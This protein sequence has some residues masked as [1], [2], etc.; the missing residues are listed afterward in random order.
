[1]D[2]DT[3]IPA[4]A[5]TA[6]GL[7]RRVAA[8]ETISEV[9]RRLGVIRT[10]RELLTS[11]VELVR[12]RLGYEAAALLL[13]DPTG[14]ELV[15][16][17]DSGLHGDSAG[18]R[19]PLSDGRGITAW[20]ATH[21]Q[22]LLADDVRC[23]PRY[24]HVGDHAPS[25]SELAV[26]IEV[27]GRV[28]GVLDVQSA[29]TNAFDAIDLSTLQTLAGQIAVALENARLHEQH[30]QT[31]RRRAAFQGILTAITA[32]LDLPVTLER[33]LDAAMSEFAADRAAIFF[34][35]PGSTRTQCVAARNLSHAYLTAVEACYAAAS[36]MPQPLQQERSIFIEDAQRGSLVPGMAEAA[37]QEG[38]HTQILL[39]LRDGARLLGVFVLYHDVIRPYSAE[40]LALVQT[41]AD[42]AAIATTHARLHQ[43]TERA[44]RRT[45]A[46]QSVTN[47]ITGSLDLPTTLERALDAAMGIF[48]ADRAAIMLYRPQ[49]KQMQPAASRNL[50]AGFLTAVHDFYERMPQPTSFKRLKRE[51]S[52]YV[53]DAQRTPPIPALAEATAR[54]GFHSM[55]IV[56]L[57]N[58]ANLHGVFALFHDQIRRYTSEEIALVQSLA[59]QA[60]VAVEHA[61][62]Y[63]DSERALQR[64]RA[65]QSVS[66]A[67]TGS[68]DLPTTLEHALGAAME[69]FGADRAAIFLDHP[70]TGHTYCAAS[71]NLSER[72]LNAV[73]SHYQQAGPPATARIDS[74]RSIYVQDAQ[75]NP[76]APPL[77]GAA[78]REGFRSML[79]LPLYDGSLRFG[80]FV[81]YHDDIRRY[82]D[83]EIALAQTFAH[84]ARIAIVHAR[85][86]E[87]E[88]RARQQAATILDATRAVASS[89]QLN[90]VLREA[91]GCI[92]AALHQ[93]Y[94]GVWLLDDTGSVL[95]PVA[96]VADPPDA[97]LER[98]F[99]SMPPLV[100]DEYPQLRA[101]LREGRACLEEDL[102]SV[103][104]LPQP[105]PAA[106]PFRSYLSVP[107]VTRDQ[108]LG[109]FSVA[110][111]EDSVTFDPADIEVAL[112]IARSAALAVE[113]A[114]LYEQAQRLA[115]S[116]ERNRLA[117]ELHDSVTQSLFSMTLICQAL[118]RIL[119]R[120]PERA[121]E[122]LDRLN[123]LGRGALA[124]MRALIFELRPAALEDEGLVTALRKH[125]DAF[126]SREAILVEFEVEGERRLPAAIEEGIFRVAQ[127]AL[128][129]V[130]KHAAA[131]RVLLRLK[132][133]EAQAE[134]TVADD[135]RGFDLE[136]PHGGRRTLGL[137][138]MEERA[139]IL[140]GRYTITSA[141]GR[142]TTVSLWVPLH[143]GHE[144]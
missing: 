89:L 96:A 62:L 77:A 33:T 38:F 83:E 79:F 95:R 109:V 80:V 134:L 25:G 102:A 85:L 7:S 51:H 61:R 138:S 50:S 34:D 9:G 39:P 12:A 57:R 117:R 65:F 86:F 4:D 97:A 28:L 6:A 110:V 137:T 139:S 44:L 63:Q 93:R 98:T 21:N 45:R 70:Q 107:L 91:A 124:E 122:R 26:P 115:V 103:C 52:I 74:E 66:T 41:F 48:G 94:C 105:G 141:T 128:N 3:V 123:E 81:L 31:L 16:E 58:G 54:E 106:N 104:E 23:E 2:V 73:E 68:L 43:D 10:E 133:G 126:Q 72:Y 125:V 30:E 132:L 19:L 42:H 118:P 121:R 55:L 78:R 71:R 49:D 60:A 53:E 36:S 101:V 22:P 46:F 69:V 143:A 131:A 140:G 14:C 100:V 127:E 11:I 1:V 144:T 75:V 88:R 92:A 8:L 59:D 40:E 27:S 112:A 84:Q 119:D 13:L 113:N 67:I 15:I 99:L 114:R 111:L 90:D 64:T 135:G 56:P 108:S 47:A 17:V 76:L 24:L 35:E 18:F 82:D 87:R 129:N 116:E 32:S 5:G 142:G 29:R 130:A 136:A 37:R 20:V 120:D